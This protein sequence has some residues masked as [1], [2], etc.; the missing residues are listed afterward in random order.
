MRRTTTL[1]AAGLLGL[2]LLAPNASATAAGGTCR[3]EAATIVGTGA[4]VTGTEGRDVIVT[5]TAVVVDARGGDDLV[6]VAGTVTSSNVLVVDAGSGDD[7][8][9]ATAV[10]ASHLLTTVLGAGADT[11]AGGPARDTVHGGVRT[12]PRTDTDTDTITT[13]DGGDSVISGSGGAVNRD[14]VDTGPGDDSVN[15]PSPELGQQ[16]SVSGG[17]GTDVLRLANDAPDL[18]IDMAAGTFT[19]P[20]GTATFASLESA[21]I[22]TGP[23]RLTYRGTPGNDLVRVHPT[24]GAPLLD[25]STAAGQDEIVVEPA[26]IAAGS[27]LD[28]GEGRNVLVAASRSG[29]MALDLGEQEL[30]VGGTSVTAAGIQDAFL[31]APDVTMVGDARGNNLSFAGCTGTLRGNDGRDRL[32]N[33]FDSYFENYTYECATRTRM[34]GGSGADVLQ[35]GQGADRLLGGGGQDTIA[36]RGGDDRIRG[37]AAGDAI[38]GGEGRDD[39]RGNGGPDRLDG[40]MAAD[41]LVGGPGRDRADG[42]RGRD[43]CVAER[44]KRCER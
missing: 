7:L 9:D 42:S 2:A 39:V 35:G 23:G 4:S 5:G 30:V 43:R 31:L 22:T 29:T 36:G 16:A 26:T 38:D 13:G 24:A 44:E 27:R 37:N 34:T 3:G 11:F 19:T 25:I 28:G 18:A 12:E 10:A 1:T 15:L 40:H 14:V 8:V 20:A 21:V 32:L 17:A 6:C 41:V 33:V